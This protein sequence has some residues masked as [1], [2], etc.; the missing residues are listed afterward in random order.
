MML[1]F[2]KGVGSVKY[3]NRT[4]SRA[5]IAAVVIVFL[6]STVFAGRFFIQQRKEGLSA[7]DSTINPNTASLASLMRLPGIGPKKAQTI[8]DYRNSS[9]AELAFTCPA[10]L[11]NIKG[12]GPKTVEKIGQYLYFSREDNSKAKEVIHDR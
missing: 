11:Q 6:M 1:T 4:T 3:Q 5:F 12:I 7:I 9:L 8:I 10:D 2:G